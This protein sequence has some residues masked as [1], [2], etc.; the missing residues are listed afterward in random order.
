MSGLDIELSIGA[1]L[2]LKK[3]L[4]SI[5]LQ[6]HVASDGLLTFEDM[7]VRPR[8]DDFAAGI[9]RPEEDCE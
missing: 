9:Y 2:E 4:R 6:H 7:T 5:G 1:F 3:A 8:C